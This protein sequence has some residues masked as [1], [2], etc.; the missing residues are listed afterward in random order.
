MISKVYDIVDVRWLKNCKNEFCTKK[1]T[2]DY[3]KKDHIS[4]AFNFNLKM[5]NLNL[6]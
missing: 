4:N 2:I 5:F 1:G 3:R 6:F